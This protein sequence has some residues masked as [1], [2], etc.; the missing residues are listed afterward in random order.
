MQ[1]GRVERSGPLGRLQTSLKREHSSS[2]AISKQAGSENRK[3]IGAGT[4]GFTNPWIPGDRA[5]SSSRRLPSRRPRRLP[6]TPRCSRARAPRP[7]AAAHACSPRC[8]ARGPL[9]AAHAAA[10]S[11][12]AGSAAALRPPRRLPAGTSSRRML[13]RGARRPLQST[14][15]RMPQ[16]FG[17]GSVGSEM[18]PKLF[19]AEPRANKHTQTF[20]QTSPR[21]APAAA[22]PGRVRPGK[23]S[24]PG[25]GR[26][27]G[28]A[29]KRCDTSEF[30]YIAWDLRSRFW[31]LNHTSFC[32]A[33][34]PRRL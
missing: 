15:A 7:L 8:H 28:S 27:S 3:L 16:K 29:A 24:G 9:A 10:S 21:P 4:N 2:P 19:S 30:E 20:T 34:L 26:C 12:R 25:R 1:L 13:R 33:I 11:G 18:Q 32:S 22:D 17:S 5:L 6:E 31:H 14:R 23:S